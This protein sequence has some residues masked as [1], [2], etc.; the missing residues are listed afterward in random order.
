MKTTLATILIGLALCVSAIAQ[1]QKVD[2]SPNDNPRTPYGKLLLACPSLITPNNTAGRALWDASMK[3]YQPLSLSQCRAYLT[4]WKAE[5]DQWEAASKKVAA[6][7]KLPDLPHEKL[8]VEE[9]YTRIGQT[10][11]CKTTFGMEILKTY[12]NKSL[13]VAQRL[14]EANGLLIE[15]EACLN[16]ELDSYRELSDREKSVIDKHLLLEELRNESS[17]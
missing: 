12:K 8:S 4:L 3:A 15:E 6:S 5:D 7:E 10:R 14:A 17:K 13:T 16:N 11:A 2:C 1:E 9:L